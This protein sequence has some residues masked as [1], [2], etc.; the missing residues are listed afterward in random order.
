MNK[1][2][3]I[4][5]DERNVLLK[6]MRDTKNE[7][8]RKN[9]RRDN[10]AKIESIEDVEISDV[11]H[12]EEIFYKQEIIRFAEPYLKTKEFELFKK[13]IY[14]SENI[15]EFKRFL[16]NSNRYDYYLLLKVLKKIG[17]LFYEE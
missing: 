1:I 5:N 4:N 2:Y 8:L 9:I 11:I 10:I 16:R 13:A 7:Y 15:Y 6:I 3:F 12:L 17:G 14:N